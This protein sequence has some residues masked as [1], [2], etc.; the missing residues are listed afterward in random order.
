MNPNTELVAF[1]DERNSRWT[2]FP[3]NGYDEWHEFYPISMTRSEADARFAAARAN[4][5][6]ITC[7]ILATATHFSGADLAAP[8]DKNTKTETRKPRK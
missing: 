7:E 3:I 5:A 1:Y 8:A 6:R 4:W 2:V